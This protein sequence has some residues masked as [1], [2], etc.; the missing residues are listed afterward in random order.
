VQLTDEEIN[1]GRNNYNDII[2]FDISV[3]REHAVLKYDKFNKH[4]F[5]ENKGGKFGTLVLVRRN[6]KINEEKTFFQIS[7]THISMEL[8]NEKNFEK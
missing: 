6:I 8:S 4:L 3:S 2:D 7:N 5:L 1:I